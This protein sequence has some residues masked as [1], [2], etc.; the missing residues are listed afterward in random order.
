M[1]ILT[2]SKLKLF[3]Q[4]ESVRKKTLIILA[5]ATASLFLMAAISMADGACPYTAAKKTTETTAQTVSAK[6][7]GETITLNVSN[8][9]C[10]ACVNHVTKALSGVEGVKEVSVNLEKGMAEVVCE[11]GKVKG[12]MLAETVTKAGYPAKLAVAADAPAKT[13]TAD[14]AATCGA[15]KGCDPTACGMKTASKGGESDKK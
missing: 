1:I 5:L 14:C 6:A 13:A 15:K 3:H 10:G 12:E 8:M 9:T 7:E 4:E 11:P 2:T